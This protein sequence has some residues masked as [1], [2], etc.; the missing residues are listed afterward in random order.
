MTIHR[1][2][3]RI[4]LVA[5]TFLFFITF[6]TSPSGQDVKTPTN[7]L[8][9]QEKVF[10]NYSKDFRA[11]EG[12]LKGVDFEGVDFLDTVATTAEDRLYSAAAMSEI[13]DNISCQTDREKVRPI[14]KKR[15]LAFSWLM[16]QEADR[17]AGFLQ[18]VT[19]PA[20]A[21]MGLRMKDDLRTTKDKLN[22]IAGS[23]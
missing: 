10:S 16:D 13:Y 14:L 3:P 5:S 21:Q 2:L 11:L 8:S 23:L 18:F 7:I 4:P 9:A 19:L 20:A 6:P 12:S 17:T 1:M 22:T 15:L